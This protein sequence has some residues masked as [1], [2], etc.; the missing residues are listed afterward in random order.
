MFYHYINLI[1]SN[2]DKSDH[3]RILIQMYINIRSSGKMFLFTVLHH[4]I[5]VT[6][7]D[8]CKTLFCGLLCQSAPLIKNL[9]GTNI[10]F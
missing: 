1:Q 9:S 3:D 2:V 7:K 4:T 8:T 10:D 6:L 5:T